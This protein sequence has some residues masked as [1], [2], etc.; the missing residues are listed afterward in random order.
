MHPLEE[1]GDIRI[2]GGRM[3]FPA[4]VKE[5]LLHYCIR[6]LV[7][8]KRGMCKIIAIIHSRSSN[9]NVRGDAQYFA[10]IRRSRRGWFSYRK[11]GVRKDAPNVLKVGGRMGGP[12]RVDEPLLHYRIR[13]RG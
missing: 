13:H 2:C 8:E 1:V 6:P 9:P 4:R 7:N 3:G 5:P 10:L 11:L 12:A